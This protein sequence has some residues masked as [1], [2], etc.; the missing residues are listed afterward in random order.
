MSSNP[1]SYRFTKDARDLIDRLSD[2]LGVSRTAVIEL[3]VRRLARTE[4]PGYSPSAP[5]R[6]HKRSKRD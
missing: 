1:T 4:L 2:A 3:A 6:S 5:N